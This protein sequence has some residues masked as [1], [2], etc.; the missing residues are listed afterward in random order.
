VRLPRPRITI[1]ALLTLALAAPA[2]ATAATGERPNVIVVV[3]DDQPDTTFTPAT[4]P[5]VTRLIS[6]PGSRFTNSVVPTPLCC[7]SRSAFLSGEFGHNNGVLWNVP[8][9][10][11]LKEKANT[12]PVWM[13]RAG[14]RTAHVGKYLNGYR[15]TLRNPARAAPGWSE[16]HTV[17]DPTS[18]YSAPF[19]DNGRLHQSGTAPRDYTTSIINRTAVHMIHRFGAGPRPLFMVV[20]QF[21]P[22]RSG[23]PSRV[24]SCAPPGPEPAVRD[25]DAFSTAPLPRPPSFNEADVSDKPAFIRN[26]DPYGP[27]QIAALERTYRCSL[28]SLQEVDRGVAD[29]WRELGRIGERRNTALVFTSD[30]G[31][32]FGEHRLSFEKIVPYRESLDVPLSIRLPGPP[33]GTG[34]I[35]Q[36]V[37]NVDLP[38]T[39]LDLADADPCRTNSDCRVLDGRS[40]VGLL[41]GHASGWPDDRAI[42]LELDTAGHPA[43]PDTSCAYQGVRTAETIYLHHTSIADGTG[44]CSPADES[45]LYDLTDDPGQLT[46]LLAPPVG[47]GASMQEMFDAARAARLSSCVGIQGRDP[48]SGARPFCE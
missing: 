21:A 16:W 12:L 30:N 36:L 19:S 20:D 14:F 27:E 48:R 43:D 47:A 34:P 46:N 6:R 32:Y 38:A 15:Y 33:I 8:G 9:Y 25:A 29:I 24:P 26:R 4:M 11:D 45:E 23:G 22:H 41:E 10:R 40:L 28:A 7:P 5:N 44:T 3:T 39:I 13:R 35:D 1:S 42:P 37:A 2:A 17:L 18:Y 31:L